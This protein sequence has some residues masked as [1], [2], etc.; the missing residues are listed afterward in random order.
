MRWQNIWTADIDM[1]KA[2]FLY[3]NFF[4]LLRKEFLC[5]KKFQEYIQ[6]NFVVK[7]TT[8]IIKKNYKFNNELPR[9]ID[10]CIIVTTVHVF[11]CT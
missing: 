1:K 11:V 2:S 9:L 3:T 10:R 4:F 8:T 7:K 5:E 6:I